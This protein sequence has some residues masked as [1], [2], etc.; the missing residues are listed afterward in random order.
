LVGLQTHECPECGRAFDPDDPR[1]YRRHPGRI[2]AIFAKRSIWIIGLFLFLSALVWW[3]RNWL[4]L[5]TGIAPPTTVARVATGA[6]I[7]AVV[8]GVLIAG[9]FLYRQR[10]SK[11]W[12][13]YV[14]FLLW[15]GFWGV[16]HLRSYITLKQLSKPIPVDI[17]E[18][19]LDVVL[20]ELSKT[21]GITI[22]ADWESLQTAGV[23]PSSPTAL[24]YWTPG[25]PHRPGS[26]S[27][28]Q[29]FV[30]IT[31]SFGHTSSIVEIRG[32]RVFIIETATY[33]QRDR[34]F[35]SLPN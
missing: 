25:E 33:Y 8:A 10:K 3:G 24:P 27:L 13:M 28:S 22:E 9:V 16:Y 20:V 35:I 34:P 15:F 1:S 31:E 32:G 14:A 30:T 2:T 4:Y 6:S 26:M 12:L 7:A 11:T 17:E 19:R 18:E 23:E 21:S 5:S 29:I